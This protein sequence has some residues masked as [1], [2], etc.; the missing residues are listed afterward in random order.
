[1]SLIKWIRTRIE[2]RK[3]NKLQEAWKYEDELNSLTPSEREAM[4]RFQK[5]KWEQRKERR[6]NTMWA[7]GIIISL[8]ILL[9]GI[10]N[11]FK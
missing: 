5:S 9:F 2:K 1:M 7:I 6:K 10:L 4:E 3:W 11:Y 8:L